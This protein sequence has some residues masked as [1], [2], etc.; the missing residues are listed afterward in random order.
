MGEDGTE[1]EEIN[2]GG[3]RRRDIGSKLGNRKCATE[4]KWEES[5]RREYRIVSIEPSGE[6]ETS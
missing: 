5:Q 3:E 4:S 2:G 6:I 1:W